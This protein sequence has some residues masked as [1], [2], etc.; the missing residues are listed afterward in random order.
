M[1]KHAKLVLG[2]VVELKTEGIN[3]VTISKP[4]DELKCT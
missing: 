3:L 1:L 4:L 2:H